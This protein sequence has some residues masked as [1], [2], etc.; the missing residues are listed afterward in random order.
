MTSAHDAPARRNV[1]VL[2]LAQA[3]LGAQMPMIFTIGG[4]AGQSLASNICFATLPISLIVLGSML[5]A[6]PVSWL[7]QQYGRRAGFF[8]GAGAGA[9][10]GAVGA[11]GLYMASFPIFLLGSLI[12]GTYMSAQGF[13]RFA[14]ADTA[15]DEF[16]PKAIS[17]VMAGGLAS[18]IIGPQLVKATSDAFV[19]PFL[20]TYAAVIALNLLG[21]LLFLFLQIPRPPRPAEDAPKGRTRMQLLATPRIAVAVICA[22]V[23][24]ALMNLVM[25]STPLAVV[26]CGFETNDAA[27]VVT[28]HV[29]AM[30]APSFFTGH[31]IARFGVEKIM[32]TGLVILAGAGV[33]GLS[34]VALEQFFVALVLLGLGWNFGFIG[35]TTMLAGAHE[36]HERG[37][38]QGLNDL[39]VFGGVTFASL[40]SGGLMNCSGGSA[41][42]GW[43]AVNLAM[44]PFLVLAGGA[45]IWLVLRPRDEAS[46]Q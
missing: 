33:V 11:Y 17:Y 30:F 25:T 27:N 37:R 44:A 40:A 9:L 8:V 4:L 15:S 21:A 35:A 20:G 31:L 32:A 19:V 26:G 24:Y 29:L 38:M 13:Y 18:A 28:A 41:Q 1:V 12:T 6:T 3:I 45:L 2:V 22:T 16:R 14:A 42:Q 7:M 5:S 46:A 39:I 34:G 36:P 23:S 43:T 10:G